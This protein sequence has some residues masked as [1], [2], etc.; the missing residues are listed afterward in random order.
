MKDVQAFALH[1]LK[2][3]R[4]RGKHL[5][6]HILPLLLPARLGRNSD[7]AALIHMLAA[8]GIIICPGG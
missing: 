4:V 1:A 5:V 2:Q 3:G 6:L 8:Q 7:P